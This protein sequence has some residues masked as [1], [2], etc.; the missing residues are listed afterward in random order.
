MLKLPNV[1]T[2]H[3]LQ[4]VGMENLALLSSKSVDVLSQLP[5]LIAKSELNIINL[6]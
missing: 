4:V 6:A 5:E 1:F 2:S 3:W